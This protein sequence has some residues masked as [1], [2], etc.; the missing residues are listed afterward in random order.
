MERATEER[1]E[2]QAKK[3]EF[4]IHGSHFAELGR[5]DTIAGL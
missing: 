1:K 3:G 2:T 4:F 5:R